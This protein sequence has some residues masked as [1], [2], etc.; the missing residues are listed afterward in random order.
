MKRLLARIGST[1]L[2]MAGFA[3]LAAGTFVT[4]ETGPAVS[5]WAVVLPLALLGV[6]L[7]AAIAL[8]PALRR[9]GLGVF[10][11]ALLAFL[12]LA[13]WGRL[14]HLDGRVEVTQDALFEPGQMVV[15][16][17]GPW[18]DDGW[19]QL[20]FRQGT[21]E[22]DYAPGVRRQHTRSTLWLPGE[23]QP[24]S[25]G[26]DTP[27]VIDGYRFY[28]TSNKGFA[29]LLSWQAP[30]AEPLH[31]VLHMPG[32]P[33]YEWKQEQAWTAPDGTPLRFWLRIE[34]PIAENTAWT[35]S[36]HD[37]PTVL[38]VERAGVRRELRPGEAIEWPG[39]TL[40]Y[41]RLM[42]WMGYRVFYDP[43]MIPLLIVSLLGV[44][45]LAWHLWGRVGRLA[46]AGQG[47]PA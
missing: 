22:V 17:R 14:T 41:E 2:S 6:N 35:L 31:G 39:G 47:A 3:L 7:A 12:L 43:S 15:D 37:V 20:Q 18:H 13:A 24:R 34:R 33:L 23:R 44:A 28:T 10:H 26:D 8:R 5:L 1:R 19:K 45:G 42:G 9:G 4:G 27:L 40:R 29:P 36:P 11:L 32:Y 38:V 16:R 46:P 21:W 25:V 30:G